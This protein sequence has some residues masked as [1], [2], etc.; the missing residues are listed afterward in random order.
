MVAWLRR[1]G[2]LFML[3]LFQFRANAFC[4]V[5]DV[6]AISIGPSF[7]SAPLPP[8]PPLT[9]DMGVTPFPDSRREINCRVCYCALWPLFA[10]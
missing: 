8:H 9:F 10:S 5:E 2:C 3:L 4:C 1:Q 7:C 6:S